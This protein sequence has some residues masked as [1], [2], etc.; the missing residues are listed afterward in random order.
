M[1]EANSSSNYHSLQVTANRRFTRSLEFGM[2]WTWSKTLDYN[3]GEWGAINTVAPLR[4]WN[5]GLAG[6]D[7]THVVKLNWLYSTPSRNWSFKP[8]GALLNG[9]QISGIASFQSGAPTG[10]GY[11]QVLATD[12]SGTPS[13][14]PRILVIGDPVLPKSERTFRRNFRTEMFRLPASGTLGTMS[15]TLL[16]GPGINNWDVAIFKNFN[17]GE[18]LR[19]QFRSEFYNMFNHTQ[20]SAMDTA[21]RFDAAGNQVNARFGEFTLARD[22]RIM[23]LA[24]RLQF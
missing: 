18:T 7:R 22:P 24:V 4:E 10:V 17:I 19:V 15:K 8:A 14:A 5:Y 1:N 23:Q 9:W 13:I 11:S 12:L 20:F 16:R 2:A 21:A 6:F 3:D